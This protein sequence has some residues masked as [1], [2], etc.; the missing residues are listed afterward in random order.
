MGLILGAF[1]LQKVRLTHLD[2]PKRSSLYV[3]FHTPTD[4]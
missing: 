1:Y 4:S 3:A 2:K